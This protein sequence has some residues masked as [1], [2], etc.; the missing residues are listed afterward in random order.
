ML[1]KHIEVIM[2]MNEGVLDE[3][4]ENTIFERFH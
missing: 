1:H 4:S 2:L 3:C